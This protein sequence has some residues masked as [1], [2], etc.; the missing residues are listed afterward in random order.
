MKLRTVTARV[1]APIVFTTVAVLTVPG[2]AAADIDRGTI[3]TLIDMSDLTSIDPLLVFQNGS[4][5]GFASADSE[6]QCVIPPLVDDG[7]DLDP[8]YCVVGTPTSFSVP[9]DAA[10]D[11]DDPGADVLIWDQ[12]SQSVCAGTTAPVATIP[13]MD[14]GGWRQGNRPLPVGSKIAI[15]TWTCGSRANGITCHESTTESGFR[16]HNGTVESW[17]LD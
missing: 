2:V 1:V 5:M 17:D 4:P 10:C 11:A 16:I 3:D 6:Y 7:D 9:E 15:D 13:S 12:D 14:N 8:V